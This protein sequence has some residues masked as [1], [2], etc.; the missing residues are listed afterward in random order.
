MDIIHIKLKKD[1]LKMSLNHVEGLNIDKCEFSEWI[2][3]RIEYYINEKDIYFEVLDKSKNPSEERCT[4]RIYTNRTG[5]D[6]CTHRRK[7][8]STYCQ[9]HSTML[10]EEGV[11]RFGDIRDDIPLYDLI[12]HKS[13]IVEKIPWDNPDPLSQLQSILNEQRRKVILSTPKLIV[14]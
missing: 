13:G 2:N 7:K 12:K 5:K 9:K 1:L 3:R 8:D 10:E 4:S 14:N 6:Q 11:L